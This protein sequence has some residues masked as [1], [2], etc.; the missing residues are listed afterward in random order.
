MYLFCN[1]KTVARGGSVVPHPFGISLFEGHLFFTD[2]TKLAVM[3][4]N[5][6]TETSPQVYYQSSLRP[7]GVAI[8][9]ALRQPNGKS[10]SHVV[11]ETNDE[12]PQEIWVLL[13]KPSK[14]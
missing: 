9:H 12:T 3:K 11:M 8:Y 14:Q 2:W 6:F 5:K 4:A 1:R 13:I 7:Y 10:L